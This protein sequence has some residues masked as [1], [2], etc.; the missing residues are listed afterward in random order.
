ARELAGVKS[1]TV[2]LVVTSPPFLDKVDYLTDNWMRAWFLGLEEETRDL[3]LAIIPD[4]AGWT[5]FMVEVVREMGRILR[6]GGRAVVE[7][8]E[9]RHEGRIW[10]LEQELAERL[11][12][13]VRGA[14]IRPDQV[15]IN[16]QQFTKLS[17]CWDVK[18]N[19][20]GTNTNRCLVLIKE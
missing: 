10:N 3:E 9:V 7:V 5:D 16:A 1:G 8:G 18:N 4:P 2:D 14:V 19:E 17:N 15:L 12:L 20:K 13:K 11:P 6:K